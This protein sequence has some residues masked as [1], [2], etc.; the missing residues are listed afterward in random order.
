MPLFSQDHER[1]HLM[2]EWWGRNKKNSLKGFYFVIFDDC[3]MIKEEMMRRRWEIF[4]AVKKCDMTRE[5]LKCWGWKKDYKKI[6]KNWC[7]KNDKFH[8]KSTSAS[9]LCFFFIIL[10]LNWISMTAE[11]FFTISLRC[12]LWRRWTLRRRLL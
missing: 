3:W 11:P 5:W 8:T 6:S 10:N 1:R 9:L 4:M 2:R 7:N 12:R